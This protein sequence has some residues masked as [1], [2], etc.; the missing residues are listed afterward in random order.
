[1][2]IMIAMIRMMMMIRMLMMIRM[3]TMITMIL[4]SCHL[5]APVMSLDRS[6]NLFA[7][8]QIERHSVIAV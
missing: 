8:P 5:S 1:M 6:I 7:F 3:M 4:T 2:I